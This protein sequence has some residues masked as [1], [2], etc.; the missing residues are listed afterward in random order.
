M[1][2]EELIFEEDKARPALLS[3]ISKRPERPKRACANCTCGRAEQEEG[4]AA[5]D[6]P[7]SSCGS[8]YLGDAFRCSN[9]P[10][11]GLPPFSPNEEVRFDMNDDL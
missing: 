3:L 10:Y 9:C 5:A 8:C 1:S 6:P 11:I 2:D 7:E 4:R